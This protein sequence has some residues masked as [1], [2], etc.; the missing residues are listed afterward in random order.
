MIG[1]QYGLVVNGPWHMC[2]LRRVVVS[3]SVFAV[4]VIALCALVCIC[5][6]MCVSFVI[7]YGSNEL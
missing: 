5:S 1:S 3:C 7:A 2:Q 4:F 6:A